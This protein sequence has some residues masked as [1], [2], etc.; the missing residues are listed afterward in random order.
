MFYLVLAILETATEG[1]GAGGIGSGA[2]AATSTRALAG[3]GNSS[4][5]MLVDF[6]GAV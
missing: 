5:E 2:L 1:G 6:S 4:A 3:D